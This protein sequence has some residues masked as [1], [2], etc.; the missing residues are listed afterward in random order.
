[1]K[2]VII[3]D[4]HDNIV[5]LNKC[6]AWCKKK[7]TEELIC[8]GDVTNIET[9]EIM[10]ASFLGTIHLVKGNINLYEEK[11]I[12]KYANINNYGQVGRFKINNFDI[13]LCHEPYLIEEVKI[14]GKCD[15]IFYGHT[16]R[17]WIEEKNG[18]NIVNPGALGGM[19]QKASFALWDTTKNKIE[20]KILEKLN[21]A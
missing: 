3:S 19:F 9:I 17:P 21:L 4:I 10:A 13:G 16:H 20:L 6:L 18:V 2:V 11:D 5:N 12:K 15:Y 7:N 8:C 1:M 14:K